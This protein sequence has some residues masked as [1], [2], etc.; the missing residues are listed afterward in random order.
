MLERLAEI[1]PKAEIAFTERHARDYTMR[2]FR[3]PGWEVR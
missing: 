2:P 1:G 3:R